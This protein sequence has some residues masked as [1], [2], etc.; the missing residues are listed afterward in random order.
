VNIENTLVARYL[1][2]APSLSFVFKEKDARSPVKRTLTLK[3]YS[4]SEDYFD[5]NLDLSDSL[6]KPSVKQEQKYYG[7]VRYMHN[8]ARTYNPFSYAFEGQLGADFA[9]I[10]AEGNIRIDYHKKNKALHVRAFA[11]K[12][13]TINNEAFA[14]ER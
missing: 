7:L 5:F 12:F 14:A 4:V 6:Y 3:A 2:V 9:K 1:K 10:S 13:F 8:N 11:G